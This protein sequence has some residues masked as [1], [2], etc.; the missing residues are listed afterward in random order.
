MGNSRGGTITCEVP[1]L[2]FFLIYAAQISHR[3]VTE[4]YS[5]RSTVDTYVVLLG[6]LCR[7]QWLFPSPEA[8]RFNAQ[9]TPLSEAECRAFRADAVAMGRLKA[10]YKLILDFWGF[11]LLDEESGDVGLA[12]NHEE[13]FLNLNTP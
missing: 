11:Q 3:T 9:S 12:S 2:W 13:R 4:L 8:S 10:S 5:Q 6:V 1:T 7:S